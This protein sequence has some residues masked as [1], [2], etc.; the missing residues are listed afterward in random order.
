MQNLI[1]LFF[2]FS[3]AELSLAASFNGF[4]LENATIP[5]DEIVSG[6]P[7][8][9]GIPA[10]DYPEFEM[11]QEADWLRES[12]RIMGVAIDGEARAYPVRILDWHEIVNDRI[13]NQFIAVTYCPLCG[14]GMVFAS[15]VGDQALTFGVSGLLYNSDVLMYDRNTESLWSQIMS[16]AVAG[17]LVG[18]PLPQLPVTYTTWSSWRERH[19]ETKVLSRNTGFNR[20]YRRGPYGN[21]AATSRLMFDVSHRPPRDYHP[22]EYVLGLEINGQYK[23][24]PFKEL[25]ELGQASF[26]DELGGEE[27]TI[28]WDDGAESATVLDNTGRQLPAVTGFWF[29]WYTFHPET[30]VFK[31]AEAEQ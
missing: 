1:S 5:N 6:G 8:R 7:P 10:L 9:D 12:D 21:Y 19:P 11:A 14:T 15:N 25:R 22:K 17:P 30:L 18:T 27:V 29:A 28:V 13:G 31:H 16:E 2:L 3:L 26:S 20:D 24:Y 4:N 23:A